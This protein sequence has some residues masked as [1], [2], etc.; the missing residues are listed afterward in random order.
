[1][2]SPL[3]NK[4]RPL[5]IAGPCSA[6]SREQLIESC[7]RIA[8]IEGVDILRAGVW[9]PRTNPNSFEGVGEVA[10][11]WL[12]EAQELTKLP[13]ATEVA[14]ARHA[15]L[16][17]SYG[18]NT[19]WIG[20][21][22][23]VNPFLQQEI[24]SAVARS[25]ATILIKNPMNPDID[26]W[27]G[28][29][30]RFEKAGIPR[31]RV[32]LVHRGFSTS[33]QWRYRNDPMWHLALDMKQRHPDLKMICDPSH[34]A[35]KRHLL[36]QV[37][38]IA[39]NLNYDGL[40][41]ESHCSPDLALSDAQQQITPDELK[42]LLNA[43]SW[44]LSESSDQEYMQSLERYRSE[45][46]QIDSEIFELLS[47]RMRVSDAIGEIKRN[48]DVIILQSQRWS[49]ILERVLSRSEEL[50]L[51]EE[52]LKSILEAIHIESIEHQNRI[53]QEQRE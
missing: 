44:R 45:I 20:A 49:E 9:K 33:A 36:Q 27:S 51:S 13:V 2:T 39:A 8:A 4:K 40:I 28:A 38:Q 19:L 3:L 16:A 7:T 31:H 22:T 43:L 50:S 6:E 11:E 47:R 48:N 15:E 41:I 23:T 29:V 30:A 14:S 25:D 52:F 18:I 17:L 24:A 1:M 46:D 5:I 35:G 42:T 12:K 34:I 21:R 10:L 32:A 26:L 53:M 37:A